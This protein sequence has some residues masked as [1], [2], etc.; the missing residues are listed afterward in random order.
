[1]EGWPQGGEKEGGGEKEIARDTSITIILST[2][3]MSL[4]R[5]KKKGGTYETE[6]GPSTSFPLRGIEERE[7]KKK[8]GKELDRFVKDK[9]SPPAKEGEK[10]KKKGGGGGRK[11]VRRSPGSIPISL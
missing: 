4:E 7:K 3:A 8:G 11:T 10:K 6:H 2:S 1:L 5:G 9:F